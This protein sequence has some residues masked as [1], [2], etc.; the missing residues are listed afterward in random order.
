VSGDARDGSGDV[1]RDPLAPLS[2][3]ARAWAAAHPPSTGGAVAWAELDAGLSRQKRRRRARWAFAGALAIALGAFGGRGLWLRSARLTYAIEGAE[4]RTDGY[5][6]RVVEPLARVRFS[7]GT[8]VGLEH[9]SRAW[10]VDTG[11]H[12]AQLRLEDGRA[13]FSV[14]HR[15]HAH[16]SVEAGPFVVSVT[17]TK[18]D[19]EWSGT[20]DLLRVH[21]LNGVVTVGG[22]QT[23]GGVTLLAGQVLEARPDEGILRIEPAPPEDAGG[24]VVRQSV[25]ET[26]SPAAAPS[27]LPSF[28]AAPP[29][30]S[31]PPLAGPAPGRAPGEPTAISARS[32]PSAT[33]SKAATKGGRAGPA[34]AT[35]VA[36]GGPLDADS[37][38]S[39]WRKQIAR[40]VFQ[41]ILQ[42]AD[43]RGTELCLR[44]LP[45]DRLAVLGDAARYAGRTD[46]A[47]R[48]L[49]A[50]RARFAGSAAANEAT[51]L[52]GRLAEDAHQ[53]GSAALPW[54]ELYLRQTPSGVYAAE[55]LGREMLILGEAENDLR[56]REVARK[57][58]ET[59]PR[60]AYVGQA[61]EILEGAR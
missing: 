25:S 58:L 2:E 28:A 30:T 4:T 61:R 29:V 53:P 55:A 45:S 13:H 5:I 52:L 42:E 36:L 48:V 12:G 16:W 24:P 11:A 6:P 38:G 31:P 57:Y 33:S 7:D 50:Q 15:P 37:F 32:A 47:R 21:L 8:E 26:A 20:N 10:V 23:R 59:Y 51:F 43:A 46:L 49:Q 56:A 40:G 14:V 41:G 39:D 18:F 3:L 35:A 17:G 60:G 9:G 19:V 44:S 54:Y 34:R 22:P 27:A 1:E